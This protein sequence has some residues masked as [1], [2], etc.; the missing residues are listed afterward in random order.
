MGG[1]KRERKRKREKKEESEE[2]EDP[3]SHATHRA[4]EVMV[5]CATEIK[6]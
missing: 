2:G 5:K 6:W 1:K 4:C 3:N